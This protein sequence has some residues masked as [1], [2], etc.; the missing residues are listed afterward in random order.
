MV[1]VAHSE[2]AGAIISLTGRRNRA[3]TYRITLFRYVIAKFTRVAF[4][5]AAA[6]IIHIRVAAASSAAAIAPGRGVAR[7][8][9]SSAV[10]IVL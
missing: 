8:A 1:I 5:S 9:T 3:F 2:D 10:V 4:V 7:R 6:A